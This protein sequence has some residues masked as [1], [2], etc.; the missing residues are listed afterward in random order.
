MKKLECIIR[1]QRFEEVKAA[2]EELG[3]VGMT[4]QDVRGCGKQKGVTA[5]YRGMEYTMT[6]LPKVK[7]ELVLHDDEVEEVIETLLEVARTGEL[8]DGKVFIY[9]LEDAIRIRTG[10]RG[11]AAV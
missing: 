1:P 6:L 8:G 10:E 2:L 5:T 7:I 3:V 9:P 4:V 11:D